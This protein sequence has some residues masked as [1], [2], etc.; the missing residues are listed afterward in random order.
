MEEE[1]KILV[2]TSARHIH[3]DQA[4][5]DYLMGAEEGQHAELVS[6]APLSQPG[7]YVST[8]RL[9]L[10]G[11]PNPKTGKPRMIAGV[12][13]LG[14]LR[15]LNQVEVSA[16]DARTLGVAAPVRLSGD[17]KGSAPITLQNPENGRELHL[18]EGVIVAKRHIHMTP[19]DAEKFGVE[20]GESVFVLID[21]D[22]RTT[23]YGDTVVRV[24]E[25]F[26]L[27][28]HIDTDE[29]NA[30]GCSG[31]V[32]GQLVDMVGDCDCDSEGE[33]CC[34]EGDGHDEDC[35]CHKE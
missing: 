3:L 34:C 29:S 33:E 2:E 28:M 24:S 15:A 16:T 7:Q 32:Y 9:N 6:R 27:A 22:G 20:D 5:F 8:T 19:A 18:D 30:A 1:Y 4:A 17:V 12:S 11:E 31:T 10:I 21:T 26:S 14:P 13:I 35:C 23:I 25:K